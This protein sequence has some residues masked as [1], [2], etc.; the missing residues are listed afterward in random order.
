MGAIEVLPNTHMA[1]AEFLGVAGMSVNADNNM[2]PTLSGL[3]L[4]RMAD[5]EFL[6]GLW[7]QTK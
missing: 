6:G 1:I 4:L 7:Q 5:V 3:R 2:Q